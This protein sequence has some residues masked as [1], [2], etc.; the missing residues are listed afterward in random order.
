VHEPRLKGKSHV[1]S[2]RLVWDAW[3]KVKDNGGAAGVDGVTIEQFEEDLSGS[4]SI[5]CGI[6]CRRG[7]I[8]P[9]RS[10]RWRYLRRVGP[11]CSAYRMSLIASRKQ[12]RRR[13]WSQAPANC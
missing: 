12:P 1:I 4:A 10:G 2:K 9:G 5:G 8:T 13:R 3:L 11:G 6:G 7:R